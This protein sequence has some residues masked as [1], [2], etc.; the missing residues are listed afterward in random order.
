[1]ATA[2]LAQ[3]YP[4]HRYRTVK[5]NLECAG[6][7][8]SASGRQILESG[9]KVLY[10]KDKS[11]EAEEDSEERVLPD[12][13]EG[14]TTVFAD[15]RILE[16]VTKPPKRFT[17][18]TLIK[19]MKDIHKY[20]KDKTLV[21]QLKSV[22]GIGTEATRAGIIDSLLKS[23][24]VK[25]E[26]RNILPSEEAEALVKFLPEELTWPDM[27]AVWEDGLE[28]VLDGSLD[29]EGFLSEKIQSVRD[30]VE[31][32][33]M[34][35]METSSKAHRCPL[36]GKAL[37]R[38]KSSNGYFWGCSGFPS[39]KQTYPDKSGKPDM[40]AGKSKGHLTGL[41]EKCPK[42]GN[43]LRQIDS[44]NGK[45]WACE[46]RKQCGAKFTDDDNSPV[47]V[48]CP[49]CGKGYM[50][51]IKGR[52]GFFWSCDRFPECKTIMEDEGGR[53]KV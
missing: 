32:A 6:E 48:K 8:F 50:R 36:C 53:P 13:V 41:V 1:V 21:K 9:W 44:V 15:G 22:S 26:K 28:R 24:L 2:Y 42:C 29:V 40:E 25:Q 47:F 19:A 18:A 43:S 34:L 46:D 14:E 5:I 31:A 37:V 3:F 11:E 27:T 20:V 17:S 10:A 51:R 23:G 35:H 4:V 45:F 16:K 52:K 49:E 7:S 38:R 30:S 12:I 39:C 33:S